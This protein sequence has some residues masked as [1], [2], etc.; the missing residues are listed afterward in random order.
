MNMNDSVTPPD[1]TTIPPIKSF[2][3]LYGHYHGYI[4]SFI[5]IFGVI[6]NIM[7][8]IVL[9]R[10]HMITPTN[11]ILTALALVDM[12]KMSVYLVYAIYFYIATTPLTIYRHSEGWMYFVCINNLVVIT[13]H[14][15]ATWLTVSLAVFRYI[16]VCHHVVANQ[17]CSLARARLTIIIVVVVTIILCIPNY[18]LYRVYNLVEE[19]PA[20]KNGTVD[21][22][23]K[24]FGYWIDSSHF[25]KNHE[26]YTPITFW[27]YGVIIKIAPCVLLTILST[28]IIYAMHQASLRRKR[29]LQQ[30][31][32]HNE[33][34]SAEHNRTTIM[35]VS[36]VL[37]FVITEFPQGILAGISG[38]NTDFFQNIYSNLGDVMDLLVLINSAI[39][40]ILYCIMSQQFRDTFRS[41][42]SCFVCD[43]VPMRNH[44]FK[45]NGLSYSTVKTEVT[46][47]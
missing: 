14:N 43:I 31:G 34:V 24:S 17:L 11:N 15:M 41:L 39:N 3:I 22:N 10:R 18:F 30:S 1:P 36:V 47:V 13:C 46:Q 6:S 5:C 29:L 21:L 44:G 26:L 32:R 12:V 9:T 45:Q 37:F 33:E 35:L 23:N 25:V 40:F 42:F 20:Y 38:L 2:S 27:I 28:C 8:I 19:E 4:S 16:F 7:N